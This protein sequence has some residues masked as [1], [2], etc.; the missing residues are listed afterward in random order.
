MPET[1]GINGGLPLL[2]GGGGGIEE[3]PSKGETGTKGE[4]VCDE[5]EK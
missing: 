4:R 5:F 1:I 2:R 3:G